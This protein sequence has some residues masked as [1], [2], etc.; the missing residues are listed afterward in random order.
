MKKV[1]L[2][3][4][5]AMML[6]SMYAKKPLKIMLVGDETMAE[7]TQPEDITDS[8]AIGWGQVLPKMLAE[9]TIVQ[10]F[11]AD[12]ATTKSVLEEGIWTNVIGNATRGAYLFI[13]FG[14]HE[15]DE[16]DYRHFSTLEYFENNLLYMLKDAKK[17]GLKVVLLT[18]TAKNFFKED[19]LYP[20][21]GAYAEGVR[22]VATHAHLPL[23]DVD[24]LTTAFLEG[25]G[26]EK[27]A[28][29][30]AGGD[31]ILLNEEGAKTVA[32]MVVRAASEQKLK[33]F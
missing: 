6:T 31:Q 2:V 23:I 20:R 25:Q 27:A 30:F 22:R 8:A 7:L 29:F 10:N 16:D 26:A 1:V 32:G 9:G 17:K 18:P 24:A 14:H 3:L 5:A 13:Q 12:G 15:Y 19:V 11:A 33:G 28:L 21:H 4:F